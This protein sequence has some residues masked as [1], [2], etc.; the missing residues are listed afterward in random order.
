MRR[1]NVILIQN[2]L[3]L[4]TESTEKHIPLVYKPSNVDTL[5]VSDGYLQHIDRRSD[6]QWIENLFVRR[7]QCKRGMQTRWRGTID[8]EHCR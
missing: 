8:F 6:W 4:I 3:S 5:D 7:M 1:R 2:I